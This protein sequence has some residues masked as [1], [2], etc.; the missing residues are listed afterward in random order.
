MRKM[1]ITVFGGSGF[2]GSHVCDKLSEAGHLVTIVDCRRSQWIRDDQS[3]I[4]GD[5]LNEEDVTNSVAGADV[6]FNFAGIAD[7]GAAN[8][9][10]PDTI[11]YNILGNANIL[12]ACVKEKVKRYIFSSSVYVY[13]NSGGFYRCSKQACELYIENYHNVYGIEYTVLRYGSLYGPRADETNAIFRFV[14]E[15]LEKKKITYFGNASALREYIHVEDAAKSSVEILKPEFANEYIILTGHQPMTVSNLFKM[16]AEILGYS[17]E[18]D[19]ENSSNND[20]YLISPYSFNPKVGKK[21][22]PPL[23]F[24]LGQGLLRVIED[25]HKKLHPKLHNIEGYLIKE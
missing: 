24:D 19:F 5:I 25:Q 16:I 22:I 21:L 18:F 8:Q 7:I 2:L 14:K 13:S 3:M 6:V 11:K 9:R 4:I 23:H 20:H 12:E 1:K 17:I 15:A 10:P